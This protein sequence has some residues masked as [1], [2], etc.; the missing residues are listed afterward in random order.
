MGNQ[1]IPDKCLKNLSLSFDV[2]NHLLKVL[3]NFATPCMYSN[4]NQNK[5]QSDPPR[6]LQLDHQIKP[7]GQSSKQPGF[8]IDINAYI[9]ILLINGKSQNKDQAANKTLSYYH[10]LLSTCFVQVYSSR[11]T[12]CWF[13]NIVASRLTLDEQPRW[14]YKDGLMN[15]LGYPRSDVYRTANAFTHRMS[16]EI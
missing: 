5:Q 3:H 8:L 10:F 16:P 15:E 13:T 12:I 7:K 14:V 4:V 1:A 11:C 2:G 6:V 9:K